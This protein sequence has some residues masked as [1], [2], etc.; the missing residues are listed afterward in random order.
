MVR[1]QYM[2]S[3]THAGNAEA[4]RRLRHF[5]NIHILL[6][7]ILWACTDLFSSLSAVSDW[8]GFQLGVLCEQCRHFA[9]FIGGIRK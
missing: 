4:H 5:K 8:P 7:L 1:Q 2:Y 6:I 9:S 3:S